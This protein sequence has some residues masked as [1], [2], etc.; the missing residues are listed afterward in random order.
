MFTPGINL[1]RSV[2]TTIIQAGTQLPPCWREFLTLG[3]AAS[4]VSTSEVYSLVRL[5]PQV[6]AGQWLVG[7]TCNGHLVTSNMLVHS[8]LPYL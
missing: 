2:V 8:L 5:Q 7:S 1:F 3:A 6:N 4:H